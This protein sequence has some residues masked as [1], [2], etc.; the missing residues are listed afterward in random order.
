[1]ETVWSF[2][3]ARCLFDRG[4]PDDE[5]FGPGVGGTGIR[6]YPHLSAAQQRL[7]KAFDYYVDAFYHKLFSSFD[8]LLHFFNKYYQLGKSPGFGFRKGVTKAL[9]ERNPS[10]AR[11]LTEFSKA[12]CYARG[13]DL[14]NDITHN[15]PPGDVD[16]GVTKTVVNTPHESKTVVTVG[17]GNRVKTKELIENM[18]D[19]VGQT[20]KLLR[21][22]ERILNSQND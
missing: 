19:L 4:I 16:S 11:V 14:R 8:M 2:V 7:L 9:A 13:Q 22:V 20:E 3:L 1:V 12:P 10:L 17:V 18:T 15:S 5:W 6:Y 21:D